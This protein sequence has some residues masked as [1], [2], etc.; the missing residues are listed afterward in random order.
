MFDGQNDKMGVPKMQFEVPACLL[1]CLIFLFE[2]KRWVRSF[3]TG[4]VHWTISWE[5]H[6]SKGIRCVPV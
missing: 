2:L 1:F 3:L 6:C 5:G 4:L